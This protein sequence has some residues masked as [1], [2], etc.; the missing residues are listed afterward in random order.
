MFSMVLVG[1]GS[2]SFHT[3]PD[4]GSSHFF[5]RIRIQR[6]D[7][8]STDPDPQ[9][10]SAVWCTT[11]SQTPRWEAHHR[12]WLSGV[13]HT[14]ESDSAVGCE[15][16]WS[17]DSSVWYTP[18]SLTPWRDAYRGAWLRVMHTAEWCTLRTAELF[19]NSNFLAKSKPNSKIF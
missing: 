19:K 18:W 6:N 14:A 16:F 17:L 3:D 4:S 10:C 2:V 7:T 12:F 11:R 8:D 13:M 9:H 15:K 1:S 5:I